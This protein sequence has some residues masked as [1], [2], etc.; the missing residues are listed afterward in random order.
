MARYHVTGVTIKIASLKKIQLCSP[1]FN[2]RPNSTCENLE[3]LR[4][5]KAKNTVRNT[6]LLFEGTSLSNK[7]MIHAI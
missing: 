7:Y 5:S 4:N 1:V 6:E 3:L 2:G